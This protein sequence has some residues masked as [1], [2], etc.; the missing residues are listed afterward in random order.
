M[1]RLSG[2]IAIVTGSTSGL[3]SVIARRFATEGAAVVITGRDSARGA[4][5]VQDIAE[6]G[7]RV[8][9][10]AA[11]LSDPGMA[12]R[13]IVEETVAAVGPPTVLINNAVA[14]VGSDGTVHQ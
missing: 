4:S 8:A 1:G 14:H 12:A 11:D 9:F 3:G 10:V 5:I 13:E 2:E 7:G 6:T